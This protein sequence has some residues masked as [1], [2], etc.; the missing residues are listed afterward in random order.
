MSNV[1]WRAVHWNETKADAD[2]R[3]ADEAK[4]MHGRPVMN[5]AQKVGHALWL[6][7]V[8]LVALGKRLI[9]LVH[10]LMVVASFVRPAVSMGQEVEQRKAHVLQQI[11]QSHKQQVG[12]CIVCEQNKSYMDQEQVRCSQYG[13]L[14]VAPSVPN[15]IHQMP[16]FN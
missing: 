15:T 14:V 7:P 9:V 5:T 16:K 10:I 13:D 1:D 8:G 11:E 6:V 4:G 3:A 12:H 2:A